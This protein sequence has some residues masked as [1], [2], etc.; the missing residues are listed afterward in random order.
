MKIEK[1]QQNRRENSCSRRF[2]ATLLIVVILLITQVSSFE[3]D[4]KKN[5]NPIIREVTIKNALGLGD[6][7]AKIKLTSPLNFQVPRGYQKVAE[8]DLT[9]YMDNNGGLDKMEFYNVKNSMTKIDRKFDYKIKNTEEVIIND[10]ETTCSDNKTCTQ[11]IIGTHTEERIVWNDF[12]ENDLIKSKQVTIGIFTDVQIGDY[13]EWIPTFYGVEIDEWAGW[14]ENLYSGLQ[15]YYG[16]NDIA[17]NLVSSTG[18][19]DLTNNG[20]D[21]GATGKVEMQ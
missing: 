17:G 8:F 15:A 20:A 1:K 6:D 16:L 4:N 14:A 10:Y 19:Y 12:N 21:Y 9:Y 2:S 5:Y 3:F 13:I 18:S 7:V 11:K